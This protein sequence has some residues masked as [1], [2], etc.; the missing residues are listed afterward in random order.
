MK[1]DTDAVLPGFPLIYQLGSG[2]MRLFQPDSDALG[3]AQCK[4]ASC[5]VSSLLM[6]LLCW[7]KNL[8]HGSWAPVRSA[9]D[10][11]PWPWNEPQCY[12]LVITL[13][14]FLCSPLLMWTCTWA[15]LSDFFLR[16]PITHHPGNETPCPIHLYV[17]Y[18]AWQMYGVWNSSKIRKVKRTVCFLSTWFE[19][20]YFSKSEIWSYR[21]IC[22]LVYI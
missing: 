21:F 13:W 11:Q 14:S 12:S 17:N 9:Q 18:S 22:N 3:T 5:S 15:L 1:A 6:H 16:V 4:E 7:K 20:I 19:Y 8:V 10:R 2:E